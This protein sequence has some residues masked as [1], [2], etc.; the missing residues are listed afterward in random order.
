MSNA[1]IEKLDAGFMQEKVLCVFVG[2]YRY[3]CYYRY[4]RYLHNKFLK[5]GAML[6]TSGIF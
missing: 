2:V 4:Y 6:G 3:F 1:V 5:N